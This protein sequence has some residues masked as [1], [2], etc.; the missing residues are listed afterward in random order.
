M[1][2]DAYDSMRR[3]MR[4]LVAPCKTGLPDIAKLVILGLDAAYMC[5]VCLN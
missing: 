3:L 2:L 4:E 1:Q 5:L